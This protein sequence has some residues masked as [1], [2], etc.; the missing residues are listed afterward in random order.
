MSSGQ[1]SGSGAAQE[2]ASGFQVN[3]VIRFVPGEY[4]EKIKKQMGEMPPEIIRPVPHGFQR[5]GLGATTPV[6]MALK[7]GVKIVEI[8]TLGDTPA[9][10]LDLPQQE[11]QGHLF[12]IEQFQRALSRS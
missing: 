5:M 10:L 8:R 2:N 9:L 1:H 7:N 6:L 11:F 4:P 12:T 3:E